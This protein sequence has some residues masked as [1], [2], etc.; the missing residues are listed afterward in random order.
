LTLDQM[1]RE[2][3]PAQPPEEALGELERE[4]TQL[5]AALERLPAAALG[6]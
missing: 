1:L 5:L 6:R 2:G 3:L 4:M